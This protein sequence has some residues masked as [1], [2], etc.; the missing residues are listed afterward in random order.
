MYYEESIENM[1]NSLPSTDSDSTTYGDNDTNIIILVDHTNSLQVPLRNIEPEDNLIDYTNNVQNSHSKLPLNFSY[2]ATGGSDIIYNN[3]HSSSSNNNHSIINNYSNSTSILNHNHSINSNSGSNSTSIINHNH[4]SNNHSSN[5]NSNSVDSYSDK[6]WGGYRFNSIQPSNSPVS[7]SPPGSS[8]NSEDDD[9]DQTYATIRIPNINRHRK[10]RFVQLTVEEVEDSVNKYYDENENNSYSTEID[11]LITYL[12]G[13]KHLFSQSK[14]ITQFK[15]N[16]LMIPSLLTTSAIT[17]FAPFLYRN[18]WSAALISCLN[19]ITTMFISIINYYKLESKCET[20]LFL[21]NQFDKLETSMELATNRMFFKDKENKNIVIDKEAVLQRLK[22]V[23]TKLTELKETHNV[24]FPEEIKRLCPTISHI[25]VFSFIK[26]TE[27]YKKG[28]ILKLKDVKNEIRYIEYRWNCRNINIWEDDLPDNDFINQ[29]NR[30][31]YLRNIKEN[32]KDKIQQYRFVY[33]KLDSV[34]SIEIQNAEGNLYNWWSAF[35]GLSR[36][37]NYN[38]N[39]NTQFNL[40][41]TYNN[42]QLHTQ[43]DTTI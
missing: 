42:P 5:S 1:D 39:N 8:A 15:L 43:R 9:D 29:H 28:L 31:Q 12:K 14:N 22:I 37:I 33:D 30:I 41:N 40:L 10:N 2:S 38:M 13:Q 4:S 25:N 11:I 3:D 23:E 7:M 21:A 20:Y 24:L 34:F 6:M 26:K 17:I 36:K 16:L 19:A 32:I 35:F 18:G 27:V